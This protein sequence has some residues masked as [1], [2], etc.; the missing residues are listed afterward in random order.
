MAWRLLVRFSFQS[1]VAFCLWASPV[2]FLSHTV[3]V[4][5]QLAFC[6]LPDDC[7]SHLAMAAPLPS[8]EMHS[9]ASHSTDGASISQLSPRPQSASDRSALRAYMDEEAE[10]DGWSTAEEPSLFE[11]IQAAMHR[12][13]PL[14]SD[15]SSIWNAS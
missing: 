5:S 2:R 1:P 11:A 15:F 14:L 9:A 8:A 3:A 10:K 6:A 13:P 4:A 12:L 7:S